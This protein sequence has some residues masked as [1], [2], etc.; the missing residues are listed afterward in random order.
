MHPRSQHGFTLLEVMLVVVIIAVLTGLATLALGGNQ[1]RRLQHEAER[2]QQ[3]LQLLRDEAEQQ[4]LEL[5]IRFTPN[6]YQVLRLDQVSLT[7]QSMQEKPF[8]AHEFALPL[9]IHLQLEGN[10]L[11]PQ[12]DDGSEQ[13]L[14]AGQARRSAPVPQLL[15]LSSGESSAF[16]LSLGIADNQNPPLWLQSDGFGPITL[17]SERPAL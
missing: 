17:S 5:G 6:G 4:Q 3:V 13:W 1:Q 7:W 15:F 9:A 2:L 11:T 14:S 12:A 10:S 16:E 8:S